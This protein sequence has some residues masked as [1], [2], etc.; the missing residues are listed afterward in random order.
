MNRAQRRAAARAA[1]AAARRAAKTAS[2]APEAASKR[3]KG[4]APSAKFVKL[5]NRSQLKPPNSN[6]R[7]TNDM[8]N[9]IRSSNPYIADLAARSAAALNSMAA[10]VSIPSPEP[11]AAG[12]YV[13]EEYVHRREMYSELLEATTVYLDSA[14]YNHVWMLVRRLHDMLQSE[15]DRP[16]REV[17]PDTVEH[18]VSFENIEVRPG[19]PWLPVELIN[20]FAEHLQYG[21]PAPWFAQANKLVYVPSAGTWTFRSKYTAYDMPGSVER[22][23][24][25]FGIPDYNALKVFESLL[26]LQQPKFQSEDKTAAVMEKQEAVLEEFQRW[27][28][29]DPW[30]RWTVEEGYNS[31]F[32]RC[33]AKQYDGSN[34][35]FPGLSE[36]VELYPYQKDAVAQILDEKN[37]LLAFDVGAGKTYIM[38][39]AAM[40]MRASKKSPKN[41]FVVPN[42]IVGQWEKIF[43]TMYPDA[44]LLVV[45]PKNFTPAKRNDVLQD[46][47]DHDYDGIIMAYSSFELIRLS[48]KEIERQRKAAQAAVR[49]D[50]SQYSRADPALTK[51][52]QY[53]KAI[54]TEAKAVSKSL[55]P[56]NKEITLDQLGITTLFLDE[57]HNFKNVPIRSS[58][59]NVAGLNLKGSQKNL[60]MLYKI[61]AVQNNHK[62]GGVVFATGTPLSNSLADCYTMQKFLQ[63][64]MMQ[65]THLDIFDNW[66]KSFAKPEY[67]CEIDVDTSKFR[68]VNRLSRFYNLPE[69]SH[70]FAGNA[71]FYAMEEDSLP[72]LRGYTNILIP[73]DKNLKA[74]MDQLV[75]RTEKIRAHAV[76]PFLDNM[77][78]VSTDG[79]KAALDLRLVGKQQID[80][81]SSKVYRCVQEVLKVYNEDPDYTQIIFCDYSTPKGNEF[82]VYADLRKHFIAAGVPPE[83]IAFVHSATTEAK[84]LELYEKVNAGQV[85]ILIGS[86]FK[87]G[88]GANVQTKLKAIHHLDIPWRPA[89]MVQREGRILRKGNT[90]DEVQIFRYITEGSFDA[91][92]WQILE[93]KQKFISQ[94]LSGSTYER[95]ATDLEDTVLTYSQVKALAINEPLM[96]TLAEKQNELRK[97]RLLASNYVQTQDTRRGGMGDLQNQQRKLRRFADLTQENADYLAG[98]DEKTFK[99]L[100]RNLADVFT[101]AVLEAEEPIPEAGR[102][103]LGFQVALLPVEQRKPNKPVLLF[104]RNG[105]DYHVAMG[106]KASGNARRVV[107]FFKRF[108]VRAEKAKEQADAAQQR[109]TGNENALQEENPYPAQIA[110][111]SAEIQK[112]QN[113]IVNRQQE[114]AEKALQPA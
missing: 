38:A 85:R 32:S 24:A 95:S 79:R 10:D 82:S 72:E 70:L 26:N 50:L 110:A 78:L 11:I 55:A 33:S 60:N 62:R 67:V 49:K 9:E 6:F 83:E 101:P 112:L 108:D 18:K 25:E 4:A 16:D 44:R 103:I 90:N 92:G 114:R 40:N 39:A 75:V 81:E 66:V 52:R 106:D 109:I 74:Y 84:K 37:T 71:A 53:S 58:L 2:P 99:E 17:G 56:K 89:D 14:R 48:A 51:A 8:I 80:G 35:K 36:N 5:F 88:I 76:P 97:L 68:Y 102:E 19:V 104:S 41:L 107:N 30:R 57:A 31:F 77:L 96:K 46:I 100:Y 27:L 54:D 64:E 34:L 87:L 45:E 61:R 73:E 94:F 22:M 105:A 93:S 111:L 28:A 59:K 13:P 86:T 23:E 43:H 69:L 98:I 65:E 3:G 113:Q 7:I 91:Y 1:A 12:P 47:K 63:P 20:D 21:G 42:N 29:Q 15:L